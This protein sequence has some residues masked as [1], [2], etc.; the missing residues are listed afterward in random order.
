MAER[1]RTER[2]TALAPDSASD[3]A[4]RTLANPTPWSDVGWEAPLLWGSCQGSG[5][6]PYKVAVDT[7]GPSYTC[8]CPS[9]KFPCK[10]VLGLLYLWAEGRIDAGGGMSAYAAEWAAKRAATAEPTLDA[11]D[12]PSAAAL[13]QTPAQREAAEKRAALRDERVRTGMVELDRWLADQV[14]AG[15]A[16][17]TRR[18]YSAAVDLAARMVD[19]QAPGVAARLREVALIPSS[20]R[21]WPERLVGEFGLLH[22]LAQATGHIDDLDAELR[23][24]VRDHLGYTT[25]RA[26]V[27]ATAPVTDHWVVVGMRDSDEEQVSLR[28]VWLHGMSTGRAALVLLFTPYGM[29]VD[30]SLLPRMV[31]AGD[32]HYYPGRVRLRALM[33]RRGGEFGSAG[34]MPR[35]GSVAEAAA[36]WR[37]AVAADPWLGDYPGLVL[38]TPVAPAVVGGSAASSGDRSGGR[39]VSAPAGVATARRLRTGRPDARTGWTLVDAVGDALPLVGSTQDLWQ[40]LALTGGSPHPVFGELSSQGLRPTSI[41]TAEGLVPL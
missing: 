40:L 4:G 3:V 29:P 37:D 7:S 36:S 28:R 15:L 23:H 6:N 11:A 22:L 27:L 8:S 39:T 13:E 20:G 14:T 32:V 16:A 9:R 25:A 24:T 2:V 19:A 17:T 5:R 12:L 21:D 41:V 10:H 31:V 38:G 34:W 1:W 35:A 33:G 26:D 30:N 18:G